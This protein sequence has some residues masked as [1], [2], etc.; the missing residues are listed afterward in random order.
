MKFLLV[1]ILGLGVVFGVPSLRAKVMPKIEPV[2]TKLG[3][4]DRLANPIKRRTA[5]NE[6]RVIVQKLEE[7]IL[8]KRKKLPTEKT[9]PQWVYANTRLAKRGVDPWGNK[10]Y[11]SRLG[12]QMEVGSNGPDSTRNTEDDVRLPVAV[13]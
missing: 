12:Q 2:L 5:E 11:L 3:L 4:G 13:R 10:Y 1:L 8:E 9:F 6:M 7:D